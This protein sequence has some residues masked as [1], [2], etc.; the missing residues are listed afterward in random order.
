MFNYKLQP[1][2]N[3]ELNAEL[4]GDLREAGF[5]LI[6]SLVAAV[7]V[8]I[9]LVSI[10][11]M[12]V[13]STASRVQARRVDLANNAART[14]IDK[15]KGGV[16]AP[17]PPNVFTTDGYQSFATKYPVFAAP[18]NTVT[19]NVTAIDVDGDGE[20]DGA[21]DLIIQA[22]RSPKTATVGGVPNTDLD[23]N[24]SANLR[25]LQSAGYDVLVRVYRG[26]AFVF[27]G[28]GNTR[29]VTTDAYGAFL[30][31]PTSSPDSGKPETTTQLQATL[32]GSTGISTRH[33]PLAVF[34]STIQYDLNF[35]DFRNRL[36]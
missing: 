32:T 20:I 35:N 18:N 5:T 14:F 16:V 27:N 21:N 6:E 26:D 13:L 2:L 15:L 4:N 1:K 24:N 3:A 30:S 11:P 17:F 10:A 28:T 19:L 22:I 29:T 33:R 31:L 25:F 7:V 36:N 34:R 8:G 23:A 9:L 12:I